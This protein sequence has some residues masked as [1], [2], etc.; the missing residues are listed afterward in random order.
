[1]RFAIG[2]RASVGRELSPS[3]L[4]AEGQK[5]AAPVAPEAPPLGDRYELVDL[6]AALGALKLIALGRSAHGC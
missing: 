5:L 4:G 3:A 2:R 6:A 1:M